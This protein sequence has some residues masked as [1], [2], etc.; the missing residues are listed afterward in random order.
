MRSMYNPEMC[1]SVSGKEIDVQTSAVASASSTMNDGQHE[2]KLANDGSEE[3]YWASSPGVEQV[4]F[5]VNFPA[6]TV[7]KITIVFYYIACDF[8][9]LRLLDGTWRS[10]AYFQG[11]LKILYYS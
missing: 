1:V 2:P 8:D 4:N 9:V 6:M 3:K 5:V 11:F 7:K 10:F